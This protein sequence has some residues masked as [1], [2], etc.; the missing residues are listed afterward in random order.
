MSFQLSDPILAQVLV[1]I[2]LSI[3]LTWSLA[4]F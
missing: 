1:P 4:E 2:V 3:G